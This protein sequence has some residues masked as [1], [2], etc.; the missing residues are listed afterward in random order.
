[1]EE[2][3]RKRAYANKKNMF[4]DRLELMKNALNPFISNRW[5]KEFIVGAAI[6]NPELYNKIR[7]NEA[8]FN[9]KELLDSLWSATSYLFKQD[10]GARELFIE[11]T[12]YRLG[13]DES[14]DPLNLALAERFFCSSCSMTLRL[15]CAPRHQCKFNKPTR[16]EFMDKEDYDLLVDV[17]RILT[18]SY[19]NNHPQPI[20]LLL[21]LESTRRIEAVIVACGLDVRT[22]TAADLDNANVKFQCLSHNSKLGPGIPIMD[23]RTAVR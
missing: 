4:K 15:S 22:A 16:P 7:I 9:S 8:E 11:E 3:R 12:R 17:F 10:Q 23:W 14:V 19:E 13:L 18:P 21:T 1:M 6:F 2:V 5:D 20:Q